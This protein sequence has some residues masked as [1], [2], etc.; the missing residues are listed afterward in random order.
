[1]LHLLSA[2]L[3]FTAAEPDPTKEPQPPTIRFVGQDENGAARFE[4]QNPNAEPLPYVGYRANAFAPPLMAGTVAPL[5]SVEVLKGG[6]WTPHPIGW[7]G[8]GVGEV[9][10]P[11][12]GK[13][14]FTVHLPDGDWEA[15]KA[16]LSWF[17]KAGPEGRPEAAWSPAVARE[18]VV[19]KKP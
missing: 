12:R 1:M 9:A 5:Y 2:L 4:V 13:A 6:K 19:L 11:A 10:I 17:K 15:M 18:K 7:C 16:G 8:T 3:A 14:S